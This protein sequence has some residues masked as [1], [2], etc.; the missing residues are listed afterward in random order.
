MYFHTIFQS[1]L[2]TVL[3]FLVPQRLINS[4]CGDNYEASG[5][6][7]SFDDYIE[8]RGVKFYRI[9]GNYFFNHDAYKEPKIRVIFHIILKKFHF[10]I[11]H[12]LKHKILLQ[13]QVK[14]SN[15]PLEICTYR[16]PINADTIERLKSSGGYCRNFTGSAYETKLSCA[17]QYLIQDCQPYYFSV[18]AFDARQ[19][20]SYGSGN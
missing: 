12:C 9:H 19:F 11:L 14:S 18:R 8:P 10:S 4:Q 20:S 16:E 3:H 1:C 7:N 13:I 6:T 2:K 17:D 15:I 5:S